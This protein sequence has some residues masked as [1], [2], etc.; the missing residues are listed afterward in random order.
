MEFLE[1]RE[2]VPGDDPRTIDWNVTAR[3]GHPFVKRYAEEREL[4]LLIVLD[5]SQS[6][7]F[8]STQKTKAEISAELTALLAFSALRN[9]DKVGM[10][11]FSDK[12]ERVIPPRKSRRHAL[13]LIREVLSQ[14]STGEGTNLAE[15]LRVVNRIS[16]RRAIV[17]I[18]SDFITDNYEKILATT[19]L[20]H[21]TIALVLTDPR[22]EELPAAGI[23]QLEDSETGQRFLL[24]T[25]RAD[26]RA[27]YKEWTQNRRQKLIRMFGKIGMDSV[28]LKTDQSYV[29]PLIRLFENRARRF[30]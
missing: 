2:Y 17:F 21:D 14:H 8:G 7:N 11:L 9:S 23:I 16:K 25:T 26:G 19:N 3:L 18:I 10:V 28:F 5:V 30:R 29:A 24:D 6:L 20:H 22:E 27:L 1:V 13:R 4:T 15:A 12:V